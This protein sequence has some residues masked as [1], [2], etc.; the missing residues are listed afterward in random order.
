MIL[1][2][3]KIAGFTFLVPYGEINRHISCMCVHPSFQRQ[4]LGAYMLNHAQ[5]ETA[6]CGYQ[7]I[8]LWTEAAMGAYQL[9]IQH[10]FKITEEKEL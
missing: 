9:Y 3:E 8:T 5:R 7:S 1:N 2:D 6:T 10:G 4:G